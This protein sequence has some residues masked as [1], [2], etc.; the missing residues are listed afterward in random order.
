[1]ARLRPLYRRLDAWVRN[2][3]R[4]GYALLGGVTSGT[5]VLLLGWLLAE[6]VVFE[7]VTMAVTMAVVQYAM[8]PTEAD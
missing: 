3:S 1:M 4:T 7:A 2:R 6:P 5:A 8:Y